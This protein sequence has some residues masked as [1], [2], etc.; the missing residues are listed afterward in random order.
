MEI[1][2]S[3]GR[4]PDQLYLFRGELPD[5][6]KAYFDADTYYDNSGNLLAMMLEIQWSNCRANWMII[7]R[8]MVYSLRE[9][10]LLQGSKEIDESKPAAGP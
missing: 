8:P 9:L 6:L 5:E 2:F 10:G 1:K 7:L 4:A 3:T